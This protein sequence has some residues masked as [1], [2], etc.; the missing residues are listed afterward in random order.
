MFDTIKVTDLE[1]ATGKLG[2]PAYAVKQLLNRLHDMR[3][4][5][6]CGRYQGPGTAAGCPVSSGYVQFLF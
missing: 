1:F 6:L 5:S 2:I 3:V 4:Y